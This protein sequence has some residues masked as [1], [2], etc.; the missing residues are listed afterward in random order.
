MKNSNFLPRTKT[1]K[2]HEAFYGIYL[3][4]EVFI[5]KQTMFGFK[6]F[7]NQNAVPIVSKNMTIFIENILLSGCL[8]LMNLASGALKQPTFFFQILIPFA[9]NPFSLAQF[10][11]TSNWYLD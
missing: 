10:F 2:A 6:K 4:L 5:R 8:T 9:S 3:L 7:A 11:S 1:R